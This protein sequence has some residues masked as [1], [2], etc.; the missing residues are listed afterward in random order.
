M[1][2]PIEEV[3]NFLQVCFTHDT[4]RYHEEE[5]DDSQCFDR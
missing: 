5:T 2:M 4:T 1:K 3:L